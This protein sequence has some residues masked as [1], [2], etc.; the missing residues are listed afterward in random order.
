MPPR[1][2][3]LLEASHTQMRGQAVVI[4]R[5]RTATKA[6]RVQ[7]PP[8]LPPPFARRR[9]CPS[10]TL[11]RN[12]LLVNGVAKIADFGNAH[13]VQPAAMSSPPSHASKPPGQADTQASSV[14]PTPK[15]QEDNVET[16]DQMQADCRKSSSTM[17][18]VSLTRQHS[19]CTDI[20]SS[21]LPGMAL[22]GS[23]SMCSM[24]ASTAGA[25]RRGWCGQ[26]NGQKWWK[27]YR[28]ALPQ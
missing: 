9:P 22:Q 18:R 25:S 1:L 7:G 21:S 5:V 19:S 3:P 13:W 14:V 27:Q 8:H 12:I 11:T 2:A 26:G 10:H 23:S 4:R 28:C 17:I 16:S 20:L 24:S 6:V 15:S